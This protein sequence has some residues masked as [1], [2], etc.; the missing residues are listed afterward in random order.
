MP[1]KIKISKNAAVNWRNNRI[2]FP[3]LIAELEATGAL[4]LPVLD[5]V[6]EEMDLGRESIYNLVD[7]AQNEWDRIRAATFTTRAELD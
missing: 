3:R 4:T 2:Q 1:A 7:R 6:A 5:K